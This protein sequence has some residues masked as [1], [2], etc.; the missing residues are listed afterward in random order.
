MITRQNNMDFARCKVKN[1]IDHI[2]IKNK[3]S[4][5]VTDCRSYE[6]TNSNSDPNN[7]QTKTRIGD[8][9]KKVKDRNTSNRTPLRKQYTN[10]R[11]N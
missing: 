7:N 10:Y 8:K 1:Q 5:S 9:A 11:T 2:L 3:H 4:K 6:R